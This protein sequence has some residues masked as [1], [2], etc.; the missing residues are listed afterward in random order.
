MEMIKK[1]LQEL[2][3]K[4]EEIQNEIFSL[5]SQLKSKKTFSKQ[6]K[7]DLFRQLFV[8]N[9]DVYA[10]RWE[11][12]DKS[13]Q[14]FY[15]ITKTFKGEDYIPLGNEEVEA[16]LRGRV[17]LATYPILYKN[18]SKYCVIQILKNDI[19]KIELILQKM[20][21]YGYYEINSNSNINV[22]IFFDELVL[23]KIAYTLGEKVLKESNIQ[24]KIFPNQDFTNKSNLGLFLEL[25]LQLTSRNENKT[26]FINI[27]TM[28]AIK[29]Q[30]LYLWQIN[31]NLKSYIQSL[32][33]VETKNEPWIQKDEEKLEL[34]MGKIEMVLYDMI[35]IKNDFLS[36]SFLNKLKELASFENPQIKILL[37]LRKPL[38][39]IPRVIKNYEED[40][41][42]LKLPRGLILKVKTLF[43]HYKIK[44]EL[45]DKRFFKEE[46]FPVVT[47][48]LREEQLIAITN[49]SKNDFSICVAPPGYGKTLIGAKIIEKRACNTLIIVNK[50]MLL[51][52]WIERFVDYFKMDKKEVGYLGKSK[53]KLNSKLDI[54]TMQSLKNQPEVIENYSQVIV[55]E[56]HHIPAV[57]FELIVKQ[58][59]G[60]YIL[61][62]SATPNR[63]DGLQPILFQQLGDI[64]YEFKKKRTVTNELQLIKTDFESTADNYSQI[65]S[66]I[67]IDERRNQLILHEIIKNSNRK[68]LIL[69]DRLEHISV[70]ENLLNE[71]EIDYVSVHGGLSK[72]DQVENIKLVYEKSIILA[73]TSFFGE[74]IDFPHLNTI[75]FATPISYYGRLIQYLGR[76]GRDGQKCLA[77]DFFDSKNAMLS[78]AYK[79]RKEGYKQMHYKNNFR[80]F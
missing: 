38:F 22:W 67:C 31:K 62:L 24:G 51:D 43:D 59:R 72:K 69:T 18:L 32:V 26:L 33:N 35:Y 78:S 30:W 53:N 27:K 20:N 45:S 25:P 48:T 15:P 16:H 55:D 73:T 11:S 56:C 39:N 4:K 70:L 8:G 50:N 63:K 40:E 28:A 41:N 79:K 60:K 76:I 49:I 10:K 64:A 2:Y 13:K 5:E 77:I 6:E 54:A 34:P 47:Y 14:N 36:K 57:T 44:Y 29:D 61:G 7:I 68:I 65:I 9:Q 37:G 71:N 42:Y 66:E 3:S 80:N 17:H 74:G 58:F 19:Y 21:I 12:P 52:Q 75:I 23:A 1:K 46:K